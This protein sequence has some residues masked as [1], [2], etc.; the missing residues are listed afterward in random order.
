MTTSAPRNYRYL[1]II[2]A[3]F[4]TVLI[5]SNIAS[6]KIL[7]FGP[8]TFDGGTIIFPLSYIFGDILTEIYGYK[9]S[10]RVIWTGFACLVL[11]ALALTG[12]QLLPPAADWARPDLGLNSASQMQTAYDALLGQTWRI[13]LGSLL[14]YWVGEFVN[15]YLLAKIKLKTQG[16]H[17]WA[18][19]ITS[20]LAGE[21]LDTIVF[22]AVAFAGTMPNDLLWSIFISNY[23]FKVGVEVLFTPITYQVVNL[24]KRLEQEDYFDWTTDF[25]P[26]KIEA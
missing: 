8:F 19:T 18:R 4:V 26:L 10:R 2:T 20:T 21:G 24:L 15:S 23:V 6:T 22:I 7:L 5:V 3:L 1:D 12:V 17:L 25:N 9:R 16:K 14:A 11:T 13:V